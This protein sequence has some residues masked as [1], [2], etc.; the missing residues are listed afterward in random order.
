MNRHTTKERFKE[1]VENKLKGKMF[2]RNK[3]GLSLWQDRIKDIMVTED[4]RIGIEGSNFM[5][6]IDE[7]S[8]LDGKEWKEAKTI[9]G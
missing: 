6:S 1:F 9:I 8:I 3:Y 5:Y 7:I 2:R 4:K